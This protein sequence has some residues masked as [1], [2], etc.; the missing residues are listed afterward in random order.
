[1]YGYNSAPQV[2]FAKRPVKV[3]SIWKRYGYKNPVKPGSEKKTWDV[4][5]VPA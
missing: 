4:T 1:M 5:F 3:E 2:T